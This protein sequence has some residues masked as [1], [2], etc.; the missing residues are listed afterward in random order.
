MFVWMWQDS[1]DDWHKLLTKG[2]ALPEGAAGLKV[3]KWILKGQIPDLGAEDIRLAL[4]SKKAVQDLASLGYHEFRVL[5][6]VDI[7]VKR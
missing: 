4:D 2:S 1:L 7:A 5:I 3:G 6:A